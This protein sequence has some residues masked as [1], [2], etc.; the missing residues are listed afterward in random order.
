MKASQAPG[1]DN[2][3]LRSFLRSCKS[4]RARGF[5]VGALPTSKA[6]SDGRCWKLPHVSTQK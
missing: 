2:G 6:I 4:E 5:R 1:I 3:E